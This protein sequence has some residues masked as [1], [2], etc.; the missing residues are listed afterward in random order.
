MSIDIKEKGTNSKEKGTAKRRNKKRNNKPKADVV[1]NKV[2][3]G[4]VAD[5]VVDAAEELVTDSSV[6]YAPDYQPEVDDKENY[7]SKDI[8]RNE[9][10]FQRMNW[11][12]KDLNTPGKRLIAQLMSL[13]FIGGLIWGIRS[14]VLDSGLF[15]EESL[16]SEF[17]A[18]VFAIVGLRIQTNVLRMPK[19][20]KD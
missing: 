3:E 19:V 5:L 7:V 11:W 6:E 18:L 1:S 9:S 12:Y 20:N 16:I 13:L 8:L 4:S 15:T 14:G 17:I 2:A 10:I